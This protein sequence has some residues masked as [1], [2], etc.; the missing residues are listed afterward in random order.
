[1]V[2]Y[3]K[4]QNSIFQNEKERNDFR[5]EWNKTTESLKKYFNKEGNEENGKIQKR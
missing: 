3:T 5:K 2:T 1:M 4:E